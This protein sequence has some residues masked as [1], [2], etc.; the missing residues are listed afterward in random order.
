MGVGLTLQAI[1]LAWL[2]SVL[3]ASVEYAQPRPPFIISGIGMGLFFAP[4]ANVFLSAVR[5]EQEGQASGAGN[6]I[7]ELGGVFG[8]AILAAIFARTGS[9]ASPQAFV[10]GVVP[11]TFVGASSSRSAR[12]PR[13]SSRANS[14]RAPQSRRRTDR[15]SPA[16]SRPRVILV[17][18]ES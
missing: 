2:G 16:S 18:T 17:R 4:V 13:S 3:S 8:V 5:P 6:A 7:R 11:A 15:S 9:F 14:A 1:G 12:P 10:D